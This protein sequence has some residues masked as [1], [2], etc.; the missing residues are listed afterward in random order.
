MGMLRTTREVIAIL[1]MSGR[2]ATVDLVYD[3][4][5]VELQMLVLFENSQFGAVIADD[6]SVQLTANP[7]AVRARPAASRSE[8]ARQKQRLRRLRV[9]ARAGR[10][11]LRL[12][13]S[14]GP[15]RLR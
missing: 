15:M 8:E 11:R 9:F 4:C 14:L 1:L 5:V 3:E 10:Q 7:L 2:D 12:R 13:G 6:P